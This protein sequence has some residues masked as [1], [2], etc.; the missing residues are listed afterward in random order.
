MLFASKNALEMLSV[1]PLP[2]WTESSAGRI[3]KGCISVMKAPF[4]SWFRILAFVAGIVLSLASLAADNGSGADP[5]P[6]IFGVLN[7]QSPIQT[8]ERWNPILRYLQRKT[9]RRFQLKMG[10]TVELT[11]AMMGREEFDLIFT[12]HNFHPGFEGKYAI[13]ARWAGKP[14]HGVIVVPHDSPIRRLTDLR[15]RAV[16]FPSAD[17]FVAYVVPTLALRSAGI[18][19]V[20]RFAGNQDGALAQVKARRVDAAAVNSRFL[21]AFQLRDDFKLRTI[22]A[23][24]GYLEIPVVIH[25]RVPSALAAEIRATLIGMAA[26]PGAADIL[27][28]AKCPGFEAASEQDYDNQ[29]QA[30]R[31]IEP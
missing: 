13:L 30:Y 16:A 28:A 8:A 26:D 3:L 12:N 21:E 11:D 1:Y 17:A 23:S 15:N 25:S 24:E 10:A 7:Q 19:V 18:G 4:S 20:E 31:L 2:A 29:R 5:P 22:H 9:G 14:I 6:L 27:K